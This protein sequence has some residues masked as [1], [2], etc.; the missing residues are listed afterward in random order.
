MTDH[1]LNSGLYEATIRTAGE[2]RNVATTT[3]I[4]ELS[5]LDLPE[6]ERV[7][8]EIA[9]VIPAGNVPGIILSGLT[10]L[11]GR[12]IN[13][14]ESRK[15]I[16]LLFRGLRL[17]V[18]MAVYGTLFAGPA[19]VLYGYQ[20]LLKLAGKDIN[21][22][23]PDGTWQFYLEFALREDSAHHTNE[24]TG[25]HENLPRHRGKVINEIDQLAAWIL[26]TA[27]FVRLL[28]QTLANEWRERVLMRTLAEAAALQNAQKGAEY[29]ELYPRWE[30]QRPFHRAAN[31]TYPE[32]RRRVF[33]A[34]WEP[35]Y[36]SLNNHAKQFFNQK[37]AAL[38]QTSLPEYQRQMSWL[39]YL[40]PEPHSE[41][42][43]SYP[44]ERAHIGVIWQGRYHLFELLPATD[45]NVARALAASILQSEN[46]TPP[47][48]ADDILVTARREYQAEL[49]KL[50]DA[51]ARRQ[52]D[53]LRFAPV[54]INWDEHDGRQPL[55][56]IRRAKRGV[57]DH[58]L[59]L[60]RTTESMVFD[61]S[62]IFFDG[63]WGAAV[64][65]VITNEA[66]MWA[67]DLVTMSAAR[68]IARKLYIPTLP[69][70]P[71]AAREAAKHQ[72]GAETS[73]ENTSTKMKSLYEL[74]K[75]LKQRSDLAQIT[76]NDLFILYRSL[77]A[78]LYKPS[79]KLLDVLE[80]LA[81]SKREDHRLAAQAAQE[82]IKQIQVKNPAILI[83]IDASR[84]D[85]RERVYPT[86]FRNPLTDF[87]THHQRA[88][89]A[90]HRLRETKDRG[91]F[92]EFEDAQTL[93]LRLVGGF[94]ELLT[95]YKQI[96]LRGEST[97]TASIKFLAHLPGPIRKLLDT[98]P[99]T[100]DVL[101]EVI[102]GEEVFSNTGRV[103]VGSS[104]RRFMTAKDDNQLKTL[105]WGVQTDDKN[106]AHISLR[107][108]R[109]HVKILHEAKLHHIAQLVV[110]DY[111]NA[112]VDG[113][114]RYIAELSE[115][116]IASAEQQPRRK[117]FLW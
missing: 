111:L 40:E 84:Y 103:A 11:D 14:D 73:A 21:T 75:L 82:S 116:T 77:H 34:F 3:R 70:T 23:F 74:R 76:V 83:P 33:D 80:E 68:P 109:P 38:E 86:T 85:P 10:R 60:I 69:A 27:H 65:Q 35:Y 17:S 102:K 56:L 58:A 107:D 39:A 99:N 22:A 30:R 16:N 59:T 67:H 7:T 44:P 117:G 48:K 13:Q 8:S 1:D 5:Q 55:S 110:Q 64:A 72:I 97:S 108:F 31:E 50:L 63:A 46:Q 66:L 19:A 61:Q 81:M 62:H 18:D 28:P 89:A 94:G 100:V 92:K 112:Y 32:S 96:A 36:K 57:G 71:K 29:R 95:R 98:I 91:A 37:Y 113:L 26:A 93:Y 9:R 2:L 15:H 106:V 54:L 78:V 114:N 104:L 79:Q 20:Q 115:I 45:V 101:N 43:I 105:S 47:A 6:I 25:F 49:R 53:D 12:S 4:M 51:D 41:A 52:L 90:L 24:T 42:R 88:L 87:V